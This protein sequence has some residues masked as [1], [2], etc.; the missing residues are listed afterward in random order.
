MPSL[1]TLSNVNRGFLNGC[2]SAVSVSA[3]SAKRGLRPPRAQAVVEDHRPHQGQ[4]P[5]RV[6]LVPLRQVLQQQADVGACAQRH[7]GVGPA[8]EL[9]R[10]D[11]GAAARPPYTPD[12]IADAGLQP[13][14]EPLA[15]QALQGV[16]VEL[17]K[18][19]PGQDGLHEI[20]RHQREGVEVLEGR[21]VPPSPPFPALG[22][23]GM[24][25]GGMA[26]VC[27]SSLHALCEIV[28]ACGLHWSFAD[29]KRLMNCVNSP[30]IGQGARFIPGVGR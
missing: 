29:A 14:A 13:G 1:W 15:G 10:L 2:T 21:V 12:G 4:Q 18:Q 27:R 11:Q 22:H 16:E 6:Q 7:Q 30:A 9:G 8:L 23:A 28:P 20:P 3:L 5:A 19:F 17:L 25:A 24:L 26:E